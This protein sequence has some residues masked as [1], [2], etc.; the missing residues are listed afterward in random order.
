MTSSFAS[1]GLSSEILTVIEELKYEF[2]TFI[3]AQSIPVLLSGKD[4]IGQ[5]KTGTGK[6]AAFAIP[7]L[8]ALN[9][10]ERIVSA[11]ILCPTRELSA[12]VAREVR[13]L[14]RRLPGL[15]VRTIT[16]GEPIHTQT[17]ALRRGVNVVVATPGR[18]LDHLKRGNLQM[19]DLRTVVLDEADRMLEMGFQADI[20]EILA[21]CPAARQ[22]VLFSATFPDS[23]EQ[24]SRS[25]LRDAARVYAPANLEESG[26]VRHLFVKS[27]AAEKLEALLAALSSL[28]YESAIVFANRKATVAEVQQRLHLKGAS[29]ACLHGDLEQFQRDEVMAMLRSESVRIL[30]ATDV[31][32]RGLDVTNLDLVVNYELP[33]QAEIYLHR[34]GRTGRAGKGGLAFS[35]VS[36]REMPRFRLMEE[37]MG[38][39]TEEWASSTEGPLGLLGRPAKMQMIRVS[40]GRKDKLRPGDILGA[41]T[42][43]AGGLKAEEVGKI[44]IHDRFSYVAVKLSLSQKAARD[45]EKGRIKGRKV[46]SF[47][48]A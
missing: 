2:P 32:A 16:G 12:Q 20:E 23:I 41:L 17:G 19:K 31:A 29:V 9:L 25:H 4:L 36:E 18:I 14:G 43:E 15:T 40:A 46:R 7:L 35:V 44:E 45:L 21:H 5:S 10:P 8:E 22:T 13:K 37:A 48:V 1:L 28:E 39:E 47:V 42:G 38:S 30:I 3:Q 26:R 24:L 6:T 11:L 33:D 27:E 34:I